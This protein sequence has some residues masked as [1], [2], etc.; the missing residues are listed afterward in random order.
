[1][2]NN[3]IK[4][5]DPQLSKIVDKTARKIV[6]SGLETPVTF[7]LELHKPLLSIFHTISLAAEPIATPLFGSERIRSL[8]LLLSNQQSLELLL[9]RIE[10]LSKKQKELF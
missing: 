8:N 1:M 4:N 3:H 9:E 5:N 10:L 2:N 7:F 6:S